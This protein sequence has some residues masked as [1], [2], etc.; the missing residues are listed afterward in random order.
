M[1]KN[2]DSDEARQLSNELDDTKRKLEKTKEKLNGHLYWTY[3]FFWSALMLIAGVLHFIAGWF[4][5]FHWS[6]WYEGV[7]GDMVHWPFV[8]N[9]SANLPST[10]YFAA[11]WII[12]FFVIIFIYFLGLK[13]IRKSLEV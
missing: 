4:M 2:I 11:L 3:G 12:V 8:L 7:N 9:A 5:F 13:E 10:I 6:E 1:S